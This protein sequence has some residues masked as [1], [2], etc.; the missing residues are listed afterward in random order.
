[1]HVAYWYQVDAGGPSKIEFWA[2]ACPQRHV[3]DIGFVAV[4]QVADPRLK[5]V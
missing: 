5:S 1:M 4:S 3:A 2:S